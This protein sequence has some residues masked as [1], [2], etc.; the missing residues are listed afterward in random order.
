MTFDTTPYVQRR[1]RLLAKMQSGI[2]IIPTAP[3]VPRN[4]DTHYEYRH[5]SNFYYLTGFAEP[6]RCW[7]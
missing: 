4:G 2:A 6:R 1:A 5:D 7:Y 3:E